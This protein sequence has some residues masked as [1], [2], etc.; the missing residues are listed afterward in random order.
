MKFVSFLLQ[1]AELY[2]LLD[3]DSKVDLQLMPDQPFQ[4][5]A[6]C[7][8]SP[9]AFRATMA[10]FF[11]KHAG[12]FW[13]SIWNTWHTCWKLWEV[14][15]CCYVSIPCACSRESLYGAHLHGVEVMNYVPSQD[16]EQE[17]MDGRK[18]PMGHVL[19][20]SQVASGVRT[21]EEMRR[22]EKI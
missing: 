11:S 7:F 22:E 19:E 2:G 17:K 14:L 13:N 8:T 1:P 5:A 16:G 3:T 10:V 21:L 15:T 6:Q 20:L 18:E 12:I 9:Q 4:W